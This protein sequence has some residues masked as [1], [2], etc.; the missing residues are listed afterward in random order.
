[1]SKKTIKCDKCKGKKFKVKNKEWSLVFK[2]A[3]C[4]NIIVFDK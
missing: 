2:C 4:K 1:M 3:R